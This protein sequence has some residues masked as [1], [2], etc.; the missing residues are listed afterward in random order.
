MIASV[1]EILV[2]SD[3]NRDI[4]SRE[5]EEL[6]YIPLTTRRRNSIIECLDNLISNSRE[7]DSK[8]FGQLVSKDRYM[9]RIYNKLSV[10]YTKVK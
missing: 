9:I 3:H 6:Q 7:N 1:A 10:T 8:T 5:G 4:A 2:H